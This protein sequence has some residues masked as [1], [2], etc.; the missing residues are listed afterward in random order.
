MKKVFGWTFGVLLSPV[1][2]FVVLT[3]L[4]YVPP[5]QQWAVDT[6]AGYA[7]ESLGL[8]VRVGRVRLAF[9]L[10]LE[11]EDVLARQGSDTIADIRSLVVDVELMPLLDSKVM[12]DKF[13]ID[14]AKVYTAD[15]VEAARVRLNLRRLTATTRC[16]DLGAQTVD[17][18]DI[19][20]DGADVN[21]VL[22][23]SVPEDTTKSEAK[24]RIMVDGLRVR[25]SRV[26]LSMSHD[27]IAVGADLQSL[28]MDKGDFDLGQQV[29]RV[30]RLSL[31]DKSPNSTIA[32]RMADSKYV[33][34]D[35]RLAL[36]HISYAGASQ[37]MS[38]RL[39]NLS[40]KELGYGAELTRCSGEVVMDSLRLTLCR[41]SLA[42][43]YSTVDADV[44][45]DLNAFDELHPG[46]I[47]ARA[48]ARIGYE[49]IRMATPKEYLGYLPKS[50]LALD[51]NIAGNMKRVDIR[52]FALDWPGLAKAHADGWAKN[53]T[54]MKNMEADVR[55][56]G[57]VR[58]G[59][60]VPQMRRA[61]TIA[62][63]A[64]AT[65][66]HER[67]AA[68]IKASEGR[69]RVSMKG[70]IDMRSM[71]YNADIDVRNLNLSHFVPNDSLGTLSIAMK[72]KGQGTDFT[73]P[74]TWADANVS[75]GALHYG[76]WNLNDFHAAATM[77]NGIAHADITG[78]NA[79]LDGNITLD[80]LLTHKKVAGTLAAD[81]AKVDLYRLRIM[82]R[83]FTAGLCGHI[84]L[85]TDLAE[86]FSL[87]ALLNDFTVCDEVKT[88]RP[89][90]VVADIATRPDTTWAKIESGNLSM[91][92]NSHGGYKT[93]MAAA[94]KI[95]K[96]L[97]R[98]AKEKTI[99]QAAPRALLPTMRLQLRSGSDNSMA[100][101]LKA[102]GITFDDLLLD[103]HTSTAAGITGDAHLY[104]LNY[105][106]TRI[107]TMRMNIWQ[108]ESNIRFK[109]QVRN[110]RKNPQFVFNTLFDGMILERGANINL[111]YFDAADKLGVLLGL[112]AEVAHG[113]LLLRLSPD[114]PLLGYKEFALN[115]DNYVFLGREKRIR[116]KVNLL[117]DDGQGVQLLSDDDNADALQDLTVSLHRFDLGAIT[118]VVPYCPAITGTLDGDFHAVLDTD[119]RIS[120]VSDVGVER[121]T[122][123]DCPIGN[124]SSDFA[125]LYKGD[126]QHSVEATLNMD[127]RQFGT[128]KGTYYNVGE[129][130]L[131]GTMT[132]DRFPLDI[133]NGF[134]P[135]QIM[136]L[137]GYAQG[138]M[139]VRGPL[140]R[141]DVNGQV[142]FDSAYVVSLPYGVHLKASDTPLTVSA[143]ELHFNNFQLLG[144]GDKPLTIAGG[145][146]F[147]NLDRMTINMTMRAKDYPIIDSK[148]TRHSIAYGKAI[149]DFYAA[150]TGPVS[151]MKV[152][153]QLDVLGRTDMTYILKDS[154]LT[155]D[156]Q[157]KDLVTFTDLADTAS[158][159]TIERPA[160]G[161]MDMLLLMNVENGA[162]IFCALNSQQTNYINLEGG[163]NMRMTY[164]DADGLQLFGR[165]TLNQS[166][167]KYALP[168]IPLKTFTI[169]QGSYIEFNG[170]PMNPK[171]NIAATER[172]KSLVG[173][174]TGDSRSVAFDCGVKVTKTLADMG[175]EFTLDA[176]EDMAI[177]NELAAMSIEQRGKLAVTMLTT[178]M[179]MADGNTSGFSMNG[180]LNSFLQNEINSI[181]NSA[182]RTVDISV[183]LDENVDALGNTHTDYSFRFAKRFW[184]NRV[185]FIIGG[186]I[187]GQDNSG[188]EGSEG[189]FIDN[190]SLEYRLD[191][192]AMRYLRVFYDKSKYD[193]LE[194]RLSQYG[195]GF[196]WRKKADRF[197][198]LFNFKKTDKTDKSDEPDKTDKTDKSDAPDKS[199]ES[200]N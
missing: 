11:L 154:P 178:G 56:D 33:L 15:F 172:V 139:S 9:P 126:D 70:D 5:V 67:Y 134:F 143:S 103:L 100:G 198:Q 71:R 186:K 66:N 90:D 7:S 85:N 91:A 195:G 62:L 10:D 94:E 50:T 84:D 77:K 12:I 130:R 52:A 46:Q 96:E 162:R 167:M 199:D 37:Y 16:I 6:A 101:F 59:G 21:V 187:N 160:P 34:A 171:L 175:L 192:T 40:L 150:V 76:K 109:G 97:A 131:D 73:S 36:S 35:I 122:Y 112:T 93:L 115:K 2:L 104:S 184:N 111:R 161:G 61:R 87:Q 120:V 83:P 114:R 79:L 146:N 142:Q 182:M 28:D 105:D 26:A 158:Q 42:T 188:L 47:I 200:S 43:P 136:G 108:D 95:G 152:R 63:T 32:L 163:G 55:L 128:L 44:S 177:K 165:Y 129:G 145:V 3:I 53:P 27:S 48:Q 170:E 118:S 17:L 193:L 78:H 51:A 38:L 65:A 60:I 164:N 99:D 179:Y 155:T 194:G 197:W 123:E 18:G 20:L 89:T 69:G 81:I 132:L 74:R 72:A 68:D 82:D 4:L 113:G 110:G 127:G 159:A 183:G 64:H 25:D 149:V 54:D 125:Y 148:Q 173:A 98:Q 174:A 19:V 140:S 107:D 121:M 191:E 138:Q 106:S 137:E 180:A 135:D 23:D 153:G 196:Q 92:F 133:A 49:D 190:V 189:T 181:T 8:D 117:A 176:P 144:N 45:M 141:P 168:V 116:A 147:A 166:E 151:R 29:Y 39:A 157:M 30:E 13:R 58:L 156:D 86:K 124:I 24:W 185:N 41:A 22:A 1:V 80:A 119:E 88:Y 31:R 169:Q 75:V 57:Q 14:R 102:K